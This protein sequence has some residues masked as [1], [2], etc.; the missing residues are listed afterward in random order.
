VDEMDGRMKGKRRKEKLEWMDR[1]KGSNK[2]RENEWKDG[3]K[4]WK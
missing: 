4:E 1:S 3:Q 2:R